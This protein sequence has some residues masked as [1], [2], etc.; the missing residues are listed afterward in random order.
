MGARVA[1]DTRA[2]VHEGS[3]VPRSGQRVGEKWGGARDK[4]GALESF[5]RRVEAVVMRMGKCISAAN[6]TSWMSKTRESIIENQ[7]HVEHQL[8][9]PLRV[10]LHLPCSGF[11]F[12]TRG[13][14]EPLRFV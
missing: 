14:R 12:A 1:C 9:R 8:S 3:S 13:E 10:R 2:G 4:K 6:R 11:A 5:R 7:L